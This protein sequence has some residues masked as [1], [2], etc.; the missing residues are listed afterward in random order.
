MEYLYRFQELSDEYDF[1]PTWLSN[2]EMLCDDSF[3][4]FA[5]KNADNC[6]IGIHIHAWNSPP[7][8]TLRKD[9]PDCN[10]YLIEY[11]EWIMEEKIKKI[12]EEFENKFGYRPVS[13][14]AGRWGINQK[15]FQLLS[16][17]GY[18]YDCSITPGIDWSKSKGQTKKMLG[19]NY[20]FEKNEISI[21][22]GIIEIPLNTEKMHYYANDA[23][24]SVLRSVKRIV[25]GVCGQYIYLRPG[26]FPINYLLKMI[27]HVKNSDSTYLML[28]LH[29]SEL[30]PGGSPYFK[31]KDSIER[32]Y[33]DIKVIFD[34]IKS[35]F[36][37]ATLNEYGITVGD[38]NK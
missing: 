23:N 11:P 16:K 24:C 13:H 34:A 37:G 33:G 19:P 14:R 20:R 35:D 21:R 4:E 1:K 38:G 25:N 29:S 5:K 36:V 2:W 31:T 6:E 32:L 30:M 3:M 12:T 8:Y 7:L 27:E 9:R 26:A 22:E 17:Y 10:P 28:M 15:Y 18:K